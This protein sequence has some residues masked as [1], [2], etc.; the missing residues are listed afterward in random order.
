[1]ERCSPNEKPKLKLFRTTESSSTKH[2]LG[3]QGRY[4][5]TS[6]EEIS[7]RRP[8]FLLR[9]HRHPT[10]QSKPELSGRPNGARPFRRRDRSEPG[11]AVGGASQPPPPPKPRRAEIESNRI[12]SNRRRQPRPSVRPI[13]VAAT[14]RSATPSSLRKDRKMTGCFR[15]SDRGASPPRS[16]SRPLRRLGGPSWMRRSEA[17]SSRRRRRGFRPHRRSRGRRRPRVACVRSSPA[18]LRRRCRR[19]PPG[20]GAGEP[21]GGPAPSPS[22]TRSGPSGTGAPISR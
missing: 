14:R 4:P 20:G 8:R 19:R 17:P 10:T 1:M 18:A 2:D 6:Q 13:I 22:R 7:R 12:E 5:L 11:E 15:G 9:T 21:L 16:P 3:I